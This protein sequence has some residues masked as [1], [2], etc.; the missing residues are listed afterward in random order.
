M[1]EPSEGCIAEPPQVAADSQTGA[2]GEKLRV[3]FVGGPIAAQSCMHVSNI[4]GII[5]MCQW[6]WA[7]G[8]L[9][10]C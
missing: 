6:R 8:F 1:I 7:F 9:Q 2:Y 5:S 4:A 3:F 10:E